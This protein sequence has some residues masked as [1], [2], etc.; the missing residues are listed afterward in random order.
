MMAAQPIR[1]GDVV[2]LRSGGP[3]M[4]VESVI[5]GDVVNCVWFSEGRKFQTTFVCQTLERAEVRD[6]S[7]VEKRVQ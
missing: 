5:S 1:I 7:Q 4:V 6:L 2:R 3:P